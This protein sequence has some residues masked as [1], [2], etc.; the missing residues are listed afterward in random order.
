MPLGDSITGTTCYPQLLSQEL[1]AQ[2]HTSFA[3]IGTNDNDQSCNKAAPVQTEGHGGYLVTYVTQS[4][5]PKSPT[6]QSD[7]GKLSELQSWAAEKP[8]VVLMHFGTNDAWNGISASDVLSSYTIVLQQFR[9]QNPSVI[10]FVAQ[11]LPLNPS[12]CSTCES[13]VEALNKQIPGWASSQT[14]TASP[15]Y[16]VDVWS[17]EVKAVG[18]SAASYAPNSSYTSDGVHPT[19]TGAQPVADAWATALAA[20]SIP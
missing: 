16:V 8:D 4:N 15:I 1:I 19:L 12:G 13:N 17:A 20:Q 9:D 14:T 6:S 18:G 2:G 7:V 5:P 3:F 10:F 11:I